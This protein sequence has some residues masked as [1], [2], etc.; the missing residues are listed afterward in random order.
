[1]MTGIS[2]PARKQRDPEP[3]NEDALID[4]ARQGDHEAFGSLVRRYE[5]LVFRIAGGFL[6]DRA[7]V[8]DIAQEAFL[9]AFQAIGRFRPG[10][11]FGPWIGR[12]A[13]NLCYDR[14]RQRRGRIELSWDDLPPSEQDTAGRMAKGRPPDDAMAAR[15]LAGRL[16]L[17]LS[18]RDRQVLVLV[19]ALGYT[20]TEAAEL[21]G[22]SA[23]VLRVRLHR[24]RGRAR[25]LAARLLPPGNEG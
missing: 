24:A 23:L 3:E 2:E 1:M 12:I 6:R 25:E 17:A 21:A 15:E 9:R 11:R 20:P 10:A 13:V 22:C 4:L 14:L 18:A 5:R 19:D 16:L 8:E 7:E